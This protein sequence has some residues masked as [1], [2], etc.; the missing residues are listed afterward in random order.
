MKIK[1]RK[2]FGKDIDKISDKKLLQK[3][4]KIINDLKNQMIYWKLVI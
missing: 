3:I 1:I 4:I 2:R